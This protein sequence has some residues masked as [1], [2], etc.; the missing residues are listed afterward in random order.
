M[1][2]DG[3]ID[4]N[5]EITEDIDSTKTYKLSEAKI[6]GFTDNLEAL[7]QSIRK[8][9]GTEQYEYPIYS[10]DY[11]IELESLVGKSPAYVQVEMK[12]RICECLLKDKRIESVD[13]FSF[14]IAGD[15]VLC[16]FSVKSIYGEV[17]I[18]KEMNI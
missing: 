1:I 11:G 9:L 2:P 6:Q 5:L 17:S 8:V 18:S 14:A 15:E 12:R 10:F 16:T 13:N 4:A 7:Q 3:I